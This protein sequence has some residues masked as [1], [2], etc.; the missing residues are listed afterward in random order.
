MGMDD[1]TQ[2]DLKRRCRETFGKELR[3]VFW[4]SLG[5][6]VDYGIVRFRR[7]IRQRYADADEARVVAANVVTD[8]R[9]SEP[10]LYHDQLREVGALQSTVHVFEEAVVLHVGHEH[11]GI[12][13]SYDADQSVDL[14][15]FIRFCK[16]W[17]REAAG[18]TTH[19]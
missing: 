13:V 11:T 10:E 3:L 8:M 15:D 9:T 4:Y 12:V 1:A 17:L 19:H 5:A 18:D 2:R 14:V 16:Q 7:D 6:S